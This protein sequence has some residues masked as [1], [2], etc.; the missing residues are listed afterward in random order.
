MIINSKNKRVFQ[1]CLFVLIAIVVLGIG[2]ASISAINLIINGKI[3]KGIS[4]KSKF[5]MER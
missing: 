1:T 4:E 2:Y 3:W 5:G